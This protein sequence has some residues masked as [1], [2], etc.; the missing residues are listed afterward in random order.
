MAELSEF[1]EFMYSYQNMVYSTAF[2]ILGKATDASDISQEVFLRAYKHYDQLRDNPRAGGWLRRVARNLSLNQ[3]T[4]YRNRWRFFSE[5]ESDDSNE[6]FASR[7]AAEEKDVI[8][9]D[10]ERRQELLAEA[11]KKLPEKQRVPLVLY[12]YEE[13]SY[14][15]IAKQL[16]VSLGKVKTDIHRARETLRKSIRFDAQGDMVRGDFDKVKTPKKRR[17]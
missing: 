7:V 2:R 1:E 3:I 4:R 15:D 6:D 16:G 17:K 5:L 13:M 9:L 10:D 12:H 11:L 8:Q 14:D